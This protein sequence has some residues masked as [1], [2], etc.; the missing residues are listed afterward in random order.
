MEDVAGRQAQFLLIALILAGIGTIWVVVPFSTGLRDYR[1]HSDH[2]CMHRGD[3]F[4]VAAA[5]FPHTDRQHTNRPYRD[6]DT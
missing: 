4:G 3:V 6:K 2:C 5:K 1:Y